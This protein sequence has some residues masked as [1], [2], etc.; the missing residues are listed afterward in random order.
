V[1][2]AT[3]LREEDPWTDRIAG[4]FEANVAVSRSR[5]EV[6]LNRPRTE[7]VYRTP[8][9]SWDIQVWREPLPDDVVERS[10]GVYEAFYRDLGQYLDRVTSNGPF[11]VLDIHSYN[12]RRGPGR[13]A[14]PQ[15]GNPDI[16]V[17]TGSLS[18]RWRTVVDTFI[19]ALGRQWV[20][21]ERLDV[22]E[23]VRFKG[24]H[25]AAWIH[26]HYPERGCV[27][28]LEFKKTF[29]DE[30][31]GT[32]D[33]AHLDELADALCAAVPNVLPSLRTAA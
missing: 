1:D 8:A 26:Q 3:R 30:W 15:A 12:H 21:N 33:L 25:L 9:D 27:L 11:L 19:D 31:S 24:A 14:A 29:M 6:D 10:L 4:R 7:A 23:N 16:N 5:F 28:A 18:A 13:T 2:D 20:R 22:R 32:V 17:G